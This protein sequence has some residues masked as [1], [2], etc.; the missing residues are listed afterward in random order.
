[1]AKELFAT[2]YFDKDTTSAKNFGFDSFNESVASNTMTLSVRY[3][4]ADSEEIPDFSGL[5]SL[6]FSAMEITDK[7]DNTVPYFGSYSKIDD[8]MVNYFSADGIF[9]VNVTL[10]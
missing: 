1:M 5:K 8:I 7:D 2:I 9:T 3:E 10:I 4:V 6:T